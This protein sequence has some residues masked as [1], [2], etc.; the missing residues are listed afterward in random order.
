MKQKIVNIIKKIAHGPLEPLAAFVYKIICEMEWCYLRSKWL[1]KGERKPGKDE[2]DFVCKN[3]TFIYKS[4]ERQ[5]MAGRLYKNIQAY[6]PGARVVIADDSRKPLV[7]KHAGEQLK[8]IQLPFNSGLSRGLNCAIKQ[9]E[10]SFV[11]RMDDDELLTPL[12][13]LGAELEFLCGHQEIDLVGFMPLS[14]IKCTPVQKS[15]W[16]YYKQSLSRAPKALLIPHMTPIDENHVVVAKAPNIFLA[17]TE[18]V[19]EIGWDDKIRMIDHNEFFVRAAG[20]L[21][22]VLNPDSVVFHYHNPFHAHYQKFRADVNGD[23]AYISHKRY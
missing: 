14:V 12:T 7:I 11:M 15:V 6:Y 17:R 19:R 9:V 3:V 21:V 4:F 8:I 2:V 20:N 1:L 13:K 22:S 18:K 10:T 16:E 23:I 5:K